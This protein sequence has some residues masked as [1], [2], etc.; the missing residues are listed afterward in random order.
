METRWMDNDIYGHV[1]NVQYYSFFDTAVNRYLIQN[2]G[3][4]IHKAEVI[5]VCVE[6][7][8]TYRKSVAFPENIDAGLRVSHLGNRS[9][10]YEVGLF[11]EG[12]D[13]ACAN[14]YFVHVFVNRATRKSVTI[15]PRIL[16]ALKAIYISQ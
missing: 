4:D 14:G 13:S 2:G 7:K 3:L 8:C 6:S 9:V 5:G 15:P 12:E 1:N 10:R 11:K 16:E